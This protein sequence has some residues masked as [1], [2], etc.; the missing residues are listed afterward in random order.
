MAKNVCPKCGSEDVQ[1]Q[2]VQTESVSKTKG[3]T[4]V[5]TAKHKGLFYWLFIGW[6]LWFVKMCFIPITMLFALFP[7]GGGKAKVADHTATTTTKTKN[8]TMA[9]CQHCGHTWKA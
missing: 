8:A 4:T 2:V 6:W 7:H 3:Y 5:N 1:Y 9:V